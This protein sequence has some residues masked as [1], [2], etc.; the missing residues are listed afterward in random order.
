M[1]GDAA[2]PRTEPRDRDAKDR[3]RLLADILSS[4]R[5]YELL[6]FRP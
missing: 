5:R 3:D 1:D 2:F 4:S 6:P